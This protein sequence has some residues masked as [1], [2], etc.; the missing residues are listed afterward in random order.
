MFGI[1]TKQDEE[2]TATTEEVTVGGTAATEVAKLPCVE[3]LQI[4]DKDTKK[5]ETSELVVKPEQP[6]KP[7]VSEANGIFSLITESE[8]SEKKEEASEEPPK[9]GWRA[10]SDTYAEFPDLALLMNTTVAQLKDEFFLFQIRKLMSKLGKVIV[11]YNVPE[12]ELERLF[13]NSAAL[14]VGEILVAPAYLSACQR[15]NKKHNLESLHVGSIIDFPFGESSFKSKINNIKESAHMGVD[16]VTVMMPSLL[17]NVENSKLFKSQCNKIGRAFKKYSGIAL[18]ATDL[19]EEQIKRAMKLSAKSKISFITFAFGESTLEDLK[20]KMEIINKY[21]N[22]KKIHVIANV[23]RAEGV[24]ELFRL[25]VDKILTPFADFIGEDL[26]K[27]FKVKSV[28][29]F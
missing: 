21:R 26:V 23:D 19:D 9:N 1:K 14:S 18:N 15:Q 20:N 11:R 4:E 13:L 12:A 27:R 2:L 3:Q 28:D 17:T 22:G 24:M 7:D 6:L 25:S 10:G 8:S 16:G 5:E 29:L